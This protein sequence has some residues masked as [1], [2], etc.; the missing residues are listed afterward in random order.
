MR[1]YREAAQLWLTVDEECLLGAG[2]E[3]RVFGV[4]GAAAL[5][6]KLFDDAGH[7]DRAAKL[8]AMLASPPFGQ[9]TGDHTSIAWPEDLLSER[10]GGPIVGYVMP[11]VRHGRVIDDYYNPKARL[12]QCP[13]FH[14]EYLIVVAR[15]LAAAMRSLH[16]RRYVLGDVKQSNILVTPNALVTLVD[17]DSFQVIDEQSGR[18]F[19]CPVGTPEYTPPELQGVANPGPLMPHHDLFGLATL[20][21]QLLMEGVHPF[22]GVYRGEDD[23]PPIG[24]RIRCGW[25]PYDGGHS[26]ESEASA[27]L[28]QRRLLAA[29][30]LFIPARRSLPFEVL[31]AELRNL[32]LRTFVEGAHDP[33][34]RPNAQE[35]VA[36]LDR[37]RA[38]L[39][40][41][42]ANGQHRYSSHLQFC[43]WCDRRRTVL[44]G[45]DPFPAAGHRAPAPDFSAPQHAPAPPTRPY[46]P[47]PQPPWLPQNHAMA[48]PGQSRSG[49]A[50]YL[51][52][53]MGLPLALAFLS[54]HDARRYARSDDFDP[55]RPSIEFSSPSE[56][57]P[58]SQPDPLGDQSP[59]GGVTGLPAAPASASASASNSLPIA[60]LSQDGR[61]A[62]I[63]VSGTQ[64]SLIDCWTGKVV[65]N[66]YSD[67]DR[68]F[69]ALALSHTGKL[70][71]TASA[72]EI[73]VRD[74]S[75]FN[76]RCRLQ[77]HDTVRSLAFSPDGQELAVAPID[78]VD[79]IRVFDLGNGDQRQVFQVESG[80]TIS[81]IQ[82][83][84]N[85]RR[86]YA[87]TREGSDETRTV[88]CWDLANGERSW[89]IGKRS[90]SDQF[91]ISPDSRT[92]AMGGWELD[93]RDALNGDAL[94]GQM[95]TADGLGTVQPVAY[96][97]DGVSLAAACAGGVHIWQST[98]GGDTAID[99]KGTDIIGGA[100]SLNGAHFTTI[101]RTNGVEV[102]DIGTRHRLRHF[103]LQIYS[104]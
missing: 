71:A 40:Q 5:A 84:P 86:L 99:L 44:Q 11:R 68:P 90:W 60:S 37:A 27:F 50:A 19:R 94:A 61:V 85:G 41:C 103:P 58:Q 47:T 88:Y 89:R 82:F 95:Q 104:R 3:G 83:A 53:A 10:P 21:F 33:L 96:S 75:S 102:W 63:L 64:A 55:P 79:T 4:A 15:N 7:S 67:S 59:S 24:E 14:Y 45:H 97:R 43:P 66:E 9:R 12:E 87:T 91:A 51:A 6:V 42:G 29:E 25:F 48:Q 77:I 13:L 56:G 78:G 92:V 28:R 70:M 22:A 57:L 100:F 73:V 69:A 39:V 8:A 98:V 35:W 52:A 80:E 32:F 16:Q 81:E 31:P 1:L 101:S 2:G 17:T 36:A 49:W 54:T 20:I 65:E 23:P 18:T 34:R 76:V 74:C 30:P 93:L 38:A 46:A 72:Q 26:A 62:A